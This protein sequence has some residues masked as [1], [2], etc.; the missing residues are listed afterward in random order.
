MNKAKFTIPK[1]TKK[2]IAKFHENNFEIFIVG[3]SARGLL[4]NWF[5]EDWD[6]ATNATPEQIQAIFPK[7]SFYNNDFGTVRIVFGKDEKDVFEVTTYRTESGY[8][9]FRRPKKVSWG[10]TIQEDLSRRDFTINAIALTLDDDGKIKQIIDPFGGQEDLKKKIIRA[11][12][13]PDDRFSEDGLR[14]FR[15]VRIAA[16][17]AFTIEEK[18]FNSIKK[19]AHL[20]EKIA[21]ERIKVELFKL[22]K[23]QYP[24]DG[25]IMLY[26][27]GLL[28]FILPELIDARGVA[29][30]KHHIHD[31]WTHAIES[32][33]HCPSASPITRLAALLH[34]IGKPIVAKGEGED[35]SF[36]NHEVVGAAIA[37]KIGE[38]LRLS[39]KELDLL[40]RLVRWH[41]FSPNENLTDAA[42]RRFIK[43][44]GRENLDEIIAL[45]V[46]DRLGSG[47]PETSWRTELFK[48]RLI[49]VQKKPFSVAD[50]KVDGNDVMRILKIK[51]GP[52]VGKILQQLFDEVVEDK[53]SKNN[54]A[55]LLNRLENWNQK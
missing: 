53:K 33:R 48:K 8:A 21:K 17:L 38:R 9:D 42:I 51:P 2:L 11:V 27:A 25:I 44:V 34:D 14:L 37:K 50:L 18:T 49:A 32:L 55:H 23:S 6:F 30:A 13:N 35:R 41:Q 22:L 31:V 4:T 39:K 24:A 19:Q 29:Q 52:K 16:Q 46:G 12:G 1:S 47:V 28:K 10:K 36:H 3:G 40:W 20:I 45:R 15:A 54:R 7:N 5:I 26:E 43:R